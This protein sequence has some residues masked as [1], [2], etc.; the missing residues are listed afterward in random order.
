[1][2]SESPRLTIRLKPR[3][4]FFGAEESLRL[5]E[6]IAMNISEEQSATWRRPGDLTKR[7]IHSF[8]TQIVRDSFPDE[9]GW[10]VVL[11][12]SPI[13]SPR[14]R[15]FVEVDVDKSNFGEAFEFVLQSRL[16]GACR[17]GMIELECSHSACSRQAVGPGIK[18]RSKQNKLR[19][20]SQRLR[21]FIIDPFSTG[22]ARCSRAW[23]VLIQQHFDESTRE[24]N[25][26]ERIQSFAPLMK[27]H[28]RKRVTEQS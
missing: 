5:I 12:A 7:A 2:Q 25:L 13:Q 4:K 15:F 17:L 6:N 20:R 24:R 11:E 9:T 19:S 8:G 22:N 21:C 3:H 10:L 18:T 26:C 28:V 23:R 14:E 16:F 1:M 27:E